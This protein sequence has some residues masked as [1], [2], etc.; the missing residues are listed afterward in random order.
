MHLLSK[1]IWTWIQFLLFHKNFNFLLD[2]YLLLNPLLYNTLSIE[3]SE[4]YF[5]GD[6]AAN[7]I[8][9]KISK[10]LIQLCQCLIFSIIHLFYFPFLQDVIVILIVVLFVN[11]SCFVLWRRLKYTEILENVVWI[12]E[13]PRRSLKIFLIT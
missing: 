12:F 9:F 1:L 6:E 10:I 4:E 13:W 7:I 11:Q 3:E 2:T 5:E 8:V